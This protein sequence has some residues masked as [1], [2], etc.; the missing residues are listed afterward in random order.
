MAKLQHN[1]GLSSFITELSES[2]PGAAEEYQLSCTS[3]F[4]LACV[5]TFVSTVTSVQF[6]LAL[7][8]NTQIAKF[9]TH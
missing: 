4:V 1:E 9:G 3:A 8:I 7:T 5:E 2:G 6:F